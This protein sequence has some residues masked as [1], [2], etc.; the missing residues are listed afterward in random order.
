[1]TRQQRHSLDLTPIPAAGG[2][3][4]IQQR[5]RWLGFA[6]VVRD[7]VRCLKLCCLSTGEMCAA[8]GA[9]CYR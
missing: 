6:A 7:G 1:M 8:R 2:S 9:L 5:T 3:S 4:L